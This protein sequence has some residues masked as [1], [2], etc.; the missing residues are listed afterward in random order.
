MTAEDPC[1]YPG[2]RAGTLLFPRLCAPAHGGYRLLETQPP[3][4]PFSLPPCLARGPPPLHSAPW[5]PL[6]PIHHACP[7]APTPS[8]PTTC[9]PLSPH[10]P[11]HLHMPPPPPHLLPAH[12]AL[13]LPEVHVVDGEALLRP[14]FKGHCPVRPGYHAA[15]PA[16]HLCRSRGQAGSQHG[17]S[18]GIPVSPCAPRAPGCG[19]ARAACRASSRDTQS[20]QVPYCEPLL[21]A[22]AGA[23]Q[24]PNGHPGN[25]C[26]GGRGMGTCPGPQGTQSMRARW[27]RSWARGRRLREEDPPA[28]QPPRCCAG[29]GWGWRRGAAGARLLPLG[30]HLSH[31]LRAPELVDELIQGVDRQLPAQQPHLGQQVL[32]QPLNAFQDAGAVQVPLRGAKGA[33]R[34]G[35][36]GETVRATCH[37]PTRGGPQPRA[38]QDRKVWGC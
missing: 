34:A 38:L 26:E 30:A 10:A 7:M 17:R 25:R 18:E 2:T 28:S 14:R 33:C 23:Q 9:T 37:S 31:A 35:R 24:A 19:R 4:N 12:E 27:A 22:N 5:P 32:L 13:L 16:G 8:G 1:T 21:G 15:L 20:S 36:S 29:Q 3:T 6:L 11:P